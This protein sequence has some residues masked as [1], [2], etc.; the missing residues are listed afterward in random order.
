[1][2]VSQLIGA[3]V[4]RREDPELITGNGRYVDDL[5]ATGVLYMY[6]VRSQEAHARIAGIDVARA[7]E[8]DGV[9]AV[10]TG[11]DI[12]PGLHAPL[13]VTVWF[14]PDKK[15]PGQYPIATDT[16]R[17]LGE[18]LAIVIANSKAAAEDAG[19]RIDVRYETLPAVTDVEKA[20]QPGAPLVHE[21]L[22]TNLSYD[23]KF[24]S[25]DIDAA[26][27]EAD[28]RIE[29]RILQQ[30]L[31]PVAIEPRAVVAHYSPFGK[32]LT[33]WSS[34]QVPHFVKVFLAVILGIPEQNIRVVAPDV[35]GGFGSKIRLYSEEVLAAAAS[36]KL[37]RPVKWTGDR[38]EDLK[39]T[40]HGRAQVFDLEVAGKKDGTLLG[41]RVTQT[42][43]LGAYVGM[44]GSFQTIAMLIVEGVYRWKAF[45]GRSVGVFT[46]TTP[47]DPY[48]GAGRPEATHL[49]ERA[50]DLFAKEI[51]MDPADV[52]RKNF[53]PKDAF[54]YT[55]KA[56][57]TYDSG[58]YGPALEKALKMSGYPE[59]RRRQAELRKQG[60]YLGVGL[61]T[62]VEVCGGGPA[63]ATAPNAG[64]GLW[65]S[66]IVRLHFTGKVEV[67]VG[68]S[69][70][71]QGHETPFAQMVADVLGVPIDDVEVV[72]GD[73]A[74][75]PM[76]MDTYG[77]RSLSVDGIA[78]YLSAQ[79]VR[80]KARKLAAH[81]LEAK[82][83]DVVYEGGKAFVRGAP[84]K[85]KTIQELTVAAYQANN[86]PPGMEPSLEA[87]TFYDPSNFVY[88]FGAHVCVV[89]I[90][91]ETGELKIVR[92]IAVDDCGT[93]IN[94]LVVDGQ[95]HGGVAQGISQALLEEVVYREDGQIENPNLVSYMVA[96]APDLPG[97][98]TDETV[99]LSPVNPLGVKGI[100]EAG[101]IAASAA[102]VNAIVDALSPFGVKDVDMPATPEKLWQLM[103]RNGGKAR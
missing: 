84:S 58:N 103:H 3:P 41:L 47:T 53:I 95:I 88:P 91:G 52:R 63:A 94:P 92:Y 68:S 72:H 9:V 75:G 59:L 33:V 87:T 101:T 10:F 39:A 21:E 34:T 22:G 85:A 60:K 90:D 73:T 43:D 15:S 81:L 100:G 80:E 2:A 28:V 67:V 54:P 48:R 99:T 102:V 40:T 36:I 97:F 1:M 31:F 18:P 49:I 37:G 14:V 64:V 56:G 98:E 17:Y 46:N 8:A 71:G 16:V 62:Y 50:I 20:L 55:N 19:E 65:G 93:R 12:V 89:E 27:K 4:K 61:S 11:K 83:E 7:K 30:R 42:L 79:K 86:M 45:E 35:G 82:D 76:G 5:P 78:A 77:S 29:E 74:R 13:P 6:V 44:F 69:P 26:F 66:A 24:G 25:G 57:L 23:S 96:T 38:M 32:T 51:G 70:H